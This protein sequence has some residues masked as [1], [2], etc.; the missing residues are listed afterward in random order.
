MNRLNFFVNAARVCAI[1]LCVV[2]AAGCKPDKE[3]PKQ[4]TSTTP[5]NPTNP[6]NPSNPAKSVSVGSQGGTLTTG[7]VTFTVTTANIANGQSGTVTWFTTS[8]G[9]TSGN[10]PTGVTS[11]VTSVSNNSATVTMTATAAAAVGSYYFK[12][13][14]DGVTS[15]VAT[16]TV[17]APTYGHTGFTGIQLSA[18]VY[19]KYQWS[20]Y[21][22][23]SRSYKIPSEYRHG[24]FTVT[25]GDPLSRMVDGKELVFYKTTITTTI[26]VE[27]QSQWDYE[28]QKWYEYEDEW[29]NVYPPDI[30]IDYKYPFSGME[31]CE[32]L[33]IRGGILYGMYYCNEAGDYKHYIIFSSQK[34][35]IS[36]GFIGSFNNAEYV[37]WAANIDNESNNAYS[38]SGVALSNYGGSFY[39]GCQWIEGHFICTG[40]VSHSSNSEMYEYYL[41]GVGFCGL[42]LHSRV[43]IPSY[44]I[45]THTTSKVWLVETNIK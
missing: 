8:A 19:W 43:L 15:A 12:V 23:N 13:T 1:M 25:L 37:D 33:G 31:Q 29:S 16:L 20:I 26:F 45:N 14:V 3:D 41:P 21:N 40:G 10:A 39:S 44:A 22:D 35:I 24:Y 7:S 17:S 18:G 6:N 30:Y 32:Y 28:N 42:Y 9:T 4:T 11:S 2:V 34:G 38:G 27:D 36:E 5:N